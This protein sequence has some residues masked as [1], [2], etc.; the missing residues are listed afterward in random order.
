MYATK[1]CTCTAGMTSGI[2]SEV[3]PKCA[4]SQVVGN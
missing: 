4:Q 1:H 2:Y 3:I